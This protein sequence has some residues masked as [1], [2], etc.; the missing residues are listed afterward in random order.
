M[1]R[2]NLGGSNF[3][4]KCQHY[5]TDKRCCDT[6]RCRAKSNLS[7]NWIGTVYMKHPDSKNWNNKC[8]DYKEK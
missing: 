1:S 4:E 5:A 3:C 2:F 7:S 8:E 6:K